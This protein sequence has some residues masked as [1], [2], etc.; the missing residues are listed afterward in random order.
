MDIE[1]FKKLK[2]GDKV[3]IV[4]RRVGYGWSSSGKMD[5]WLGKIMTIRTP[6]DG[7]CVQMEEDVGEPQ[8]LESWC[9]YPRMIDCKVD[10]IDCKVVEPATIEMHIIRGNKTIVR[11][12]NGKVGIARCNPQDSFDVYEGLRIAAARAYGREPFAD[13]E[14][15]SETVEVRRV[16]RLAEAGEYVEIVNP[17]GISRQA[18]LERGQI[19]QVCKLSVMNR[20][21]YVRLFPHD[22][23]TLIQISPN[24]YVV[25]ENY[26]GG[27]V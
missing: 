25:L 22:N 21:Q 27:E 18:G 6:F 10:E 24:E 14:D 12:S 13:R 8:A 7:I 3:K 1:E 9:W 11:L 20:M 26:T 23:I 4:D 5:K 15:T 16:K 17:D 19:R 2:V